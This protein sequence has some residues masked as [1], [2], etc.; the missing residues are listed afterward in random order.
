[1]LRNAVVE[2]SLGHRAVEWQEL[3]EHTQE[4]W[5][6]ALEVPGLLS[7]GVVPAPDNVRKRIP[8]SDDPGDALIQSVLLLPPDIADGAPVARPADCYEAER[9]RRTPVIDTAGC[10]TGD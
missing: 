5:H 7:E 6:S 2:H 10:E 4:E 9:A 3:R 1:M 8:S